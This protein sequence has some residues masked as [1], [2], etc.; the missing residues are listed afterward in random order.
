VNASAA[1]STEYLASDPLEDSRAFRSALGQYGTGV[2]VITTL[3]GGQP[4]G[5]T[6]NSF[7]AVSLDPPL[8]LWS[9]QNT[10]GRA[11]AF[12]SAQH[13]AV[14]VLSTGQVEVSR[15]VASPAAGTAPFDRIEWTG[16]LGGAPLID[17]AVARFECRTHDVLPGGDHR[18]LLGRVERCSVRDG[19]PLLFVQGGY[20]T[21]EP[22][23]AAAAGEAPAA[24]PADAS[25]G[26][27]RAQFAQLLTTASHRLSRGFD[28][29]RSRFGLSVAGNRVLKRLSAGPLTVEDLVVSAFLG[30]RAVEDALSQ[31]IE[32]DLVAAD[33]PLYRQTPAGR[34]VRQQVAEDARRFNE[35]ALAGLPEAD[36]AAAQRVLSA[37]AHD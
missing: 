30:P 2:A 19:G 28:E 21:A 13:F 16:G 5:M 31:L 37:L 29:H 24:A 22:F 26:S 18:I 7:A 8:I 33:G 27:D 20:A 6:V 25:I 1:P 4:V 14:N 10:S 11:A 36:V 15:I 32:A 3:S 34:A 9:V 12:T 23:P 17:G 35:A